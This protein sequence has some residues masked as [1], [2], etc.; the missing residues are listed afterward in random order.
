MAADKLAAQWL[1]STSW[2]LALLWWFKALQMLRGMPRLTD[3]TRLDK[4]L[5]PALP[6]CDGPDLTV[7]VPA[8]NEEDSIGATIRSLLASTGLRLEIIPVDDRSTDRTGE[9]MDAM[10]AEA[11]KTGPHTLQVIHNASLPEGWLGKPHALKLGADRATAPWLL[12]TDADVTFAPDALERALRAALWKGTGHLAMV[13][14]LTRMGFAEAAMEGTMSSLA[15]W[16]VRFWKVEDPK[17]RDFFGVGGFTLVRR[18]VLAAVGGMERLRMEVVEDVGI[19]WLVKRAGYRSCI[20]Y[21]PGLA[22]IRWIRGYFGLVTNLEK[23]GFAGFRFNLAFILA[24]C[25]GLALDAVVPIGATFTGMLGLA[26]GL[27]TYAAIALI[28][29]ANRRMNGVSPLTV[30]LFGPS[31]AVLAWALLRSAFLTLARGGVVWRG[32]LYPLKE[33]RKGC[34]RWYR[35]S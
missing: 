12:M 28:F 11:A 3:L 33:L 10:A 1:I 25:I 32:T 21:G 34:L 19:G 13:P 30:V 26:G 14:S 18:D 35:W 2:I 27:L 24:A 20:T 9:R 17:A 6:T 31:A 22:R 7:I 16:A 23:N 15:G 8:C 29:Q 5:L 4:K